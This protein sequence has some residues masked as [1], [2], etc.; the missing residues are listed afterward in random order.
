MNV[1]WAGLGQFHHHFTSIKT[2]EDGGEVHLVPG[3]V[4][5][6]VRGAAGPELE[7]V[8]AQPQLEV[9]QPGLEL[10]GEVVSLQQSTCQSNNDLIY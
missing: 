8:P 7:P 10:Q 9:Q 2:L 5:E 4:R 1:Q 3:A 6:W